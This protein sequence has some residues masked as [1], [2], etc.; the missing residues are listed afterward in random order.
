MQNRV[1]QNNI[2]TILV[3]KSLYEHFVSERALGG[4]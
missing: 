3:K 1:V 4:E 2:K